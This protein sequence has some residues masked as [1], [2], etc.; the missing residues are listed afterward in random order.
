LAQSPCEGLLPIT[1]GGVTLSEL[2]LGPVTSVAPFRGQGAAVSAL[3]KKTLGLS[4][5]EAGQTATSGQARIVWSG[6]GRTLLIGVEAPEGLADLAALTNQS[7]AQAVV[8]IEGA[9]VEAVLARLVPVDLRIE[10]F[11]TGATART[12]L[13]HLT[14]SVTR[15]GKIRFEIMAFRSMAQ[16]LVHDLDR[17]MTHIAG[18]AALA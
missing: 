9:G 16:T 15:T 18:R 5:P 4:F 3:L 1:R 6:R 10:A 2:A 14:V 13:G 17:A 11:P 8:Q 12:L 7:D